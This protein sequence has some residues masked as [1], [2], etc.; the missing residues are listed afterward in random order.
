MPAQVGRRRSRSAVS[1]SSCRAMPISNTTRRKRSTRTTI[2]KHGA[3]SSAGSRASTRCNVSAT[4]SN[5]ATTKLEASGAMDSRSTGK[6]DAS[7]PNTHPS[8]TSTSRASLAAWCCEANRIGVS[9]SDVMTTRRA[10]S[11]TYAAVTP[12][13]TTDPTACIAVAHW[14]PLRDR[15]ISSSHVSPTV[16]TAVAATTIASLIGRSAALP[17]FL[18]CQACHILQSRGQRAVSGRVLL[19]PTV[20]ACRCEPGCGVPGRCDAQHLPHFAILA[21]GI[22]RSDVVPTPPTRR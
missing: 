21:R 12:T 8:V 5:S 9:R 19:A 17:N 22:G 20:R 7:R 1:R 4:V 14:P 16:A 10:V 11:R 15:N 18:T 6:Y 13:S 2:S 3:C